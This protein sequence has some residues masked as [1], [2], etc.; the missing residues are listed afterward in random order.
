MHFEGEMPFKMHKIIF[1][2]RKKKNKKKF[3]CLPFL[4]FSDLLP[5]KH[6]FFYLAF[7]FKI[8]FIC[9]SIQFDRVASPFKRITLILH[10]AGLA[11]TVNLVLVRTVKNNYFSLCTN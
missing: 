3:E 10:A 1:F 7:R 6:I 2:S 4:K 11:I 9:I 5:K 8:S